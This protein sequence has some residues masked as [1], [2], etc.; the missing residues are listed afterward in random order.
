MTQA[1]H[2]FLSANSGA[3][4]Q[5]LAH[6]LTEDRGLYD[7]MILKGGPGGG[8]D[9][10][11]RLVGQT[12]EEAGTA[13]EYLHCAGAPD[14]LDGLVLPELRCALLDGVAP[15]PAEPPYPGAVGRWVDLGRFQDVTFAK[16]AREEFLRLTDAAAAA[17]AR[18]FH[19]LRAARQVELE[20][21]AAVLPTVDC[22]RLDRRM[23]GIAARELHRGDQQGRTACRFLDTVTYRGYVRRTDTVA[24]LCPRVYALEDRWGIAGP[25][26]ER[27]R[28]TAA[29]RGWDT[30]ACLAPEDPARLEHLLIPGLGLAFVTDGPEA[31]WPGKP[32]RHV[33]IDALAAPENRA[34]LRF[35]TRMAR[36]LRREAVTALAEAHDARTQLDALT[37]PYVDFDG[38]AALAAVESARLLCW[39]DR[40]R[41]ACRKT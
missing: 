14:A 12:M 27:L 20:T 22:R 13:V 5:S 31:R 24:A 4:C 38:I 40:A 7:L 30:V 25:W 33:R 28:Q 8:T 2:F 37:A 18:A 9:A 19:A 17:D 35:E 21:A 26:L 16:A 41:A 36:L 15:H 6:R 11:L 1:V 34:R 32:Y 3:G 10:F 23:A 39:L 29:E